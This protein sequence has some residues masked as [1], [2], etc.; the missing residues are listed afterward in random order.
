MT[1]AR[2]PTIVVL[3]IGAFALTAG[4]TPDAFGDCAPGCKIC[5][6]DVCSDGAPQKRPGEK[7]PKDY[8]VKDPSEE[9]PPLPG[10]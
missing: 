7:T 1:N 2:L 3:A 10:Y 9:V 5:L 6:L 4:R 8:G